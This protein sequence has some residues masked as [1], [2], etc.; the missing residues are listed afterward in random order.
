MREAFPLGRDMAVGLGEPDRDEIAALARGGFG[1]VVDLRRPDEDHEGLSVAEEAAAVKRRGMAYVNLPVPSGAIA[2]DMLDDFHGAMAR[3]PRPVYVH[4]TGGK[5]SGTFAV[6]EHALREGLSGEAAL[7]LARRLNVDYAA[8]GYRRTVRGYVESRGVARSGRLGEMAARPPA[9][10]DGQMRR[11]PGWLSG[12]LALGAVG[13]LLWLERRRPLRPFVEAPGRHDRRNLGVLAL[14]A[15][16]L[17]LVE[18]PVVEPLAETVQRRRRGLV[19]RLGL[20][21]W[22]EDLLAVAL[23]DYTL[24]LWH[25]LTHRVPLLWRFHVVHHADLDLTA[26]TALRFHAGELALSV[27]WRAAQVALI[28]TSP[29]A[30]SVWQTATLLSILFQ[31]SNLRLPLAAERILV[32]LIVTP[33]MHGIHHSTVPEETASNW[34]SG[35]TVWDVLHGT[36]RLDVPQEAVEIGVPAYRDPR[37]VALKRLLVLP[38]RPQPDAWRRPRGD[39][40]AGRARNRPKPAGDHPGAALGH[41]GASCGKGW[42]SGHPMRPT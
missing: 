23:M 33:R 9:R 8:E 38:F 15:V 35:L 27:P 16:T 13:T 12:A 18:K 2:P 30:L 7:A 34:S 3:L 28:G 10:R 19:K 39:G 26:S 20:P 11:L 42:V 29:R 32:R 14:S 1:A 4:C 25:I 24:F 6:V 17:S 22:A 5:R 36:L 41:R 40:A 31:H 21:P 37:Q